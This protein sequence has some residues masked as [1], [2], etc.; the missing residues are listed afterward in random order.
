[1]YLF[2][3]HLNKKEYKLLFLLLGLFIISFIAILAVAS[4]G[5]IIALLI[6]LPIVVILKMGIKK[7]FAFFL[8]LTGFIIIIYFSLGKTISNK[9]DFSR[10]EEIVNIKQQYK[11][12]ADTS[13]GIRLQLY[14]VGVASFIKSP[15]IGLSYTDISKLEDRMIKKGEIEPFVKE[16]FHFHDDLLNS[17]G[18]YGVIGGVG[19]IMFWMMLFRFYPTINHLNENNDV[20]YIMFIVFGI[21]ILSSFTDAYLFGSTRP[22]MIL[23]FMCSI[24]YSIKF[25]NKK[26]NETNKL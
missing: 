21:F 7:S 13:T 16:Y 3:E 12:K 17:L 18:H 15:I 24:I 25:G 9:F 10:F 19:I 23:L 11:S 22:A 26:Y 4:K 8:I 1:M 20:K 2:S 14:K 6:I 5:P